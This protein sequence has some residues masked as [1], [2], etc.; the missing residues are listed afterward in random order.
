[1]TTNPVA[2]NSRDLFAMDTL[3]VMNPPAGYV[4]VDIGSISECFNNMHSDGDELLKFQGEIG[5]GPTGMNALEPRDILY[6]NY[7]RPPVRAKDIRFFAADIKTR[8]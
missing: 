4:G 7:D 2:N 6:N 5:E 8:S 3:K 1:M